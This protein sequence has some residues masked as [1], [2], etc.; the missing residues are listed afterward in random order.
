M[1]IVRLFSGVFAALIITGCDASPPQG[2]EGA[3]QEA[4]RS[5]AHV[6]PHVAPHVAN[7]GEMCAGVAGVACGEE[8][9]CAME[10]GR[11]DVADDAGVCRARPEVCTQ[12]FAPVCGCDGKT[13][14]NA[15][16]AA[17]A[18]AKLHKT[19]SC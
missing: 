5:A 9:Y 2:A 13:Y 19:G 14:P 12:E 7:S 8:L 6:A 16:A 1:R 15:C 11:C 17:M 10:T 3:P 4:A 18:G